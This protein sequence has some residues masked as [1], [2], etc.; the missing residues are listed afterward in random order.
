[1]LPV[2]LV[3]VDN[4]VLAFAVPSIA[5][6]LE[7]SSSEQLWIVDAYSLVLA[8]LLVP[9]G[10]LGDRIGRRKILL[11]GSVGF[12]VISSARRIRTHRSAAC[13]R[14]RRTRVLRRHAHAR[15]ALTHSQHLP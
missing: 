1:M 11:I 9:M 8:G 12:A 14:P 4:T 5:Q 7:P 10:S 6:A 2:L 3:S 15:H 13:H